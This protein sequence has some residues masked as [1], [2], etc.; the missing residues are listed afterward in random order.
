MAKTQHSTDLATPKLRNEITT[1]SLAKTRQQLRTA[2]EAV[3]K[4]AASAAAARNVHL[5]KFASI[6]ITD[7]KT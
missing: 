6:P 1:E 3:D 4:R 5:L 7:Q 2:E